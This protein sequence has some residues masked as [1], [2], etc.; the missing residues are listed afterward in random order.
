M[1]CFVL[2]Y[3]IIFHGEKKKVQER[4]SEIKRAY[5]LILKAIENLLPHLIISKVEKKFWIQ[6]Q[7]LKSFCDHNL[8]KW[9]KENRGDFSLA[10]ISALFADSEQILGVTKL[11]QVTWTAHVFGLFLPAEPWWDL[12]FLLLCLSSPAFQSKFC[13]YLEKKKRKRNRKRMCLKRRSLRSCAAHWRPV[14]VHACQNNCL[15]GAPLNALL[16]FLHLLRD[17][18][19]LLWALCPKDNSLSFMHAA[20]YLRPVA[21]CRSFTHDKVRAN[22]LM[23]AGTFLSSFRSL[24]T[25]NLCGWDSAGFCGVL[26]KYSCHKS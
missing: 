6:W 7:S 21:A 22:I 23:F 8:Q 26:S 11:P 15:Q 24:T 18:Q 17:L 5:K 14:C 25:L 4:K 1:Y 13:F 2:I 12:M 19:C 3:C 9:T 10:W 16:L 20:C